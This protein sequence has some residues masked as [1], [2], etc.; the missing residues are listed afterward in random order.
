MYDST[1]WSWG[2]ARAGCLALA[3]PQKIFIARH[4]GH[5]RG[6][7]SISPSYLHTGP[8]SDPMAAS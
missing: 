2:D 5:S 8:C 6:G 7:S 1:H 3:L 4:T